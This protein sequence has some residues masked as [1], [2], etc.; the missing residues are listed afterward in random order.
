MVR[1]VELLPEGL[2]VFERVVLDHA[3]NPGQSGAQLLIVA[4]F[5]SVAQQFE[6]FVQRGSPFGKPRLKIS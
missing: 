6:E 2:E 5:H 1:V 3:Q 4:A